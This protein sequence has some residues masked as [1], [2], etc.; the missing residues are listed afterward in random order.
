MRPEPT[1]FVVDDDDAVR[2][3]I[4]LLLS[5]VGLRTETFSSAQDFL[6]GYDPNRAGCLLLDIRMPGIGGLELQQRLKVRAKSLPVIIL[7][8][9]GD[10]PAAVR[11]FKNGALDFIEKPFNDQVLLDRIQQAIELDQKTRSRSR[12]SAKHAERYSHLTPREIEILKR[13]V[14][15][16]ANKVIALELEISERT[17]ERHRASIMEKMQTHSLA[18]LMRI[19]LVLEF[20]HVDD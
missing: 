4:A 19:A 5:T 1:I 16:D 18:E 13:I 7:T 6:D 3:S 11:A 10:V 17:V 20:K 2:D 12:A 14:A 9:H 8:G 15:G